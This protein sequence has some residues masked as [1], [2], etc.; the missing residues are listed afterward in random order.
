MNYP[1][2]YFVDRQGKKLPE[3]DGCQHYRQYGG[4]WAVEIE[5]DWNGNVG[6]LGETENFPLTKISPTRWVIPDNDSVGKEIATRSGLITAVMLDSNLHLISSTPQSQLW[7]SPGGLSESNLNEIIAEI[8]LL[9]LSVGSLV[10][11]QASTPVGEQTGS[12][13][14][15]SMLSGGQLLPTAQA[16]LGLYRSV[17]N[18][19]IEIEKRPLQSFKSEIVAVDINRKLNSPQA[20]I[21]RILNPS[22]KQIITT[23][24][25]ESLDCSENQFLCYLLDVYLHNIADSLSNAI[26]NSLEDDLFLI[27]DYFPSENNPD[28]GKVS[29]FLKY[30][31]NRYEKYRVR[32]GKER[33]EK[34]QLLLDI[35]ECIQWS[36]DVRGKSFLSDIITPDV[37]NLSLQRLIKSPTYG[38]I[39]EAYNKYNGGHSSGSSRIIRLYQET[40]NL[41]VKKTW[42][43]YEIWCFVKLYS[44]LAIQLRLKL[45]A[46]AENLFESIQLDRGELSIPKNREFH[47]QGKLNTRTPINISLWY[48]PEDK[49]LRPDIK[50]NVKIGRIE[51]TY[52]FD[53]KYRNYT[54]QK[55]NQFV[56]DVIK[57]AKNKYLDK[58]N[59]KVSFIFHSDPMFD[60]WG[61]VPL[62]N[63]ILTHFNGQSSDMKTGCINHDYGAI[64]L[65][66]GI[67]ADRQIHRLIR[68][69][70]QYHDIFCTTCLKCGCEAETQTDWIPEIWA[71]RQTRHIPKISTEQELE[72]M[73]VNRN[74]NLGG[75][76]YCSCEKCGDFWVVQRCYKFHHRLL[77]FANSFHKRS[78]KYPNNWIYLCP[79]CGKDIYEEG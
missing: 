52:Y 29:S 10:S 62:E 44:A 73:I 28:L 6:L 31:K 77:K 40:I 17:R 72:E 51:K 3:E 4:S 49:G 1:L 67:S 75:A 34:L 66:P 35:H 33:D 26:K 78:L 24:S 70:F 46:N 21:S 74:G 23:A 50:L 9:A 25:V 16:L 15:Q 43:L 47:L 14:G 8:G 79:E 60:F 48:E 13:I 65:I 39:L 58:L 37:P 32:F 53:A 36:K 18:V 41:N 12:D 7:I 54:S 20:L 22:K 64:A 56:D 76:I 5:G 38:S 19:W 63:F 11:H 45:P 27:D 71:K 55:V 42:E 68:L 2:I 61:E 57:T 30:A 69:I 59:G